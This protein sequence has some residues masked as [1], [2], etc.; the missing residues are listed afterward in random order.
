MKRMLNELAVGLSA[1]IIMDG[2]YGEFQKGQRAAFAL[3]FYNETA[4]RISE[5]RGD[6]FLRRES[7]PEHGW[8]AVSI[9]GSTRSSISS[10]SA[11][12]TMRQI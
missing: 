11:I 8:K 9:S 7:A 3:E 6:V 12:S 10:R 1:W 2:N 4:L 5:H